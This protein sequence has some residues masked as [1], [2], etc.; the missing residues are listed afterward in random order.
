[1]SGFAQTRL[2]LDEAFAR[3]LKDNL[4]LR[5]GT[6]RL[7]IA[8]NSNDPGLAGLYPRLAATGQAS[9]QDND[10]RL[11][12]AN[13]Q[14]DIEVEGARSY[15]YGA[16]L[17]LN[18]TVFDGLGSWHTLRQL[19][20]QER[21]SEFDF[22]LLGQSVLLQTAGLYYEM[23]ASQEDVRIAKENLEIS[24]DRFLRF[25][26]ARAYGSGSGFDLSSARVD[27]SND[28]LNLLVSESALR[29]A[30]RRLEVQMGA[31]FD[32]TFEVDTEVQYAILP[33]ADSLRSLANQADPAL[34]RA[35]ENQKALAF[36][37]ATAGSAFWPRLD[38][39]AGYDVSVQDNEV[40]LLLLNQFNGWN[41]GLA[42]RWDLFSGNVN[43]IRSANAKL[44]EQSAEMDA[45]LQRLNTRS[46]IDNA[47]DVYQTAL[48]GAKIAER[49]TITARLNFE[50]A[51]QL[52]SL[53]QLNQS[54]FREAQLNLSQSESSVY[55]ARFSAK[56]AELEIL[57]ICGLLFGGQ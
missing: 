33:S 52:Y 15:L 22:K 2:N 1:M 19:E 31:G 13:G 27:L 23:A 42:L 37:S 49:N 9:M 29:S 20:S 53:G 25:D 24:L 44:S 17:D 4:S 30:R 57:R 39:N 21:I 55:R 43:R 40:G 46:S 45:Q 18:Y 38:L 35:Y 36:A 7:E 6:Y 8:R 34:L 14:P 11:E 5:S 32:P 56:L 16:G 26:L 54:Q 3:A 41:A 51:R 48:E 50:R 10:T 47:L 12:F 28:S